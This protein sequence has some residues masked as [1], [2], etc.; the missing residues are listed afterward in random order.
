MFKK[1]EINLIKKIAIFLFGLSNIFPT[2][3]SIYDQYIISIIEKDLSPGNPFF[4]AIKIGIIIF[5][6][7]IILG[8]AYEL[9]DIIKYAKRYKIFQK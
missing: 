8:T 4:M 2:K 3:I 5:R 7:L 1:S 6:I 9:Y